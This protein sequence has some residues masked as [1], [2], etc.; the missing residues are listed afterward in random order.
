MNLLAVTNH[1]KNFVRAVIQNIKDASTFVHMMTEG[2]I[3][4]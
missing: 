3:K 1:R 2:V 4:T